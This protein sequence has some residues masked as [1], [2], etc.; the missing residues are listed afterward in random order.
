MEQKERVLSGIRATGRLH[1][2]NFLGAVRNFVK[3]Q[4]LNYLCLYFIADFHTLTTLVNP[5]EL[6][7]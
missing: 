5:S 3:Y 1:F 4:Q 7:G 6:R 2:G